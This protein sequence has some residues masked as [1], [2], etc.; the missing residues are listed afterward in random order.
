MTKQALIQLL[1]ENE[2]DKLFG[3]LRV[4][5]GNHPELVLL[6][7]Q[8]RDLQSRIRT[9]VLPNDQANLEAAKMRKSLFDFIEMHV[10]R[11]DRATAADRST[12]SGARQVGSQTSGAYRMLLLGGGILLAALLGYMLLRSPAESDPLEQQGPASQSAADTKASP[13][14]HAT[15]ARVLNISDAVPL[16]FAAGDSFYERVYSVEEGKIESIGGG[17]SLVTI[18]VGLNFKGSINIAFGS[19][20]FRLVA[21]QLRGSLPPSNFFADVIDSRSYGE[22]DVKFEIGDDL[23][24]FSI[25]LEGKEDRKWDFSVE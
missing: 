1:A 14:R 10:E 24:R 16:T 6:E 21:P 8:W 7:G 13:N 11:P 2:V 3:L 18:K 5:L 22:R 9:G 4:H 17:R 15:K 12:N 25:F 20:G 23:T 19:D